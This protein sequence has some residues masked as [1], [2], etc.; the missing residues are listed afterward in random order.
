MKRKSSLILAILLLALAGCAAPP[1]AVSEQPPPDQPAA[2]ATATMEPVQTE[3]FRIIGYFSYGDIVATVPFDKLTHIN[4]AFLIPNDDGTF[5]P[6][7]NS[8]KLHD[9]VEQAH[10]H[11]V[12]VL[13]S[14]GGWGWD[15]QFEKAAASAETRA[16]FVREVMSIVAAY[17]LDGVDM[18]WEYPGPEQ[19]SAENNVLLMRAL[20]DELQPQGKLLTAAVV[21]YGA[22]G[23][24]VLHE[25]FE[26][27]DFLNLMAYDGPQH[28]TMEYA[29][30]SLDYWSGRGL[31]QEKLVLG[32]PFYSRPGGISYRKLVE[33]DPA[34]AQQDELDYF[35]QLNRYNGIPTMRAKTKLAIERASGVMIWTLAMDTFDEETSLLAAIYQTAY[36]AQP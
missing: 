15:A 29:V 8:W 25:V 7:I 3:P 16:V 20:Y 32:V 22:A 13:I 34:A 26:L 6:L 35:G 14:V 5:Q 4:Y 9:L 12:K 31:P 21:A 11:G 1:A 28:A 17:N 30:Q 19:E 2:Q 10:A 24:G 23:D 33:A 36:P 18:D 27:V